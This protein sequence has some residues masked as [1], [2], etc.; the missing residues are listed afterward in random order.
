MPDLASPYSCM[1]SQYLV[2][3]KICCTKTILLESFREFELAES[4]YAQS[5][6]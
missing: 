1:H 2:C 6:L 3:H 5:A 4:A